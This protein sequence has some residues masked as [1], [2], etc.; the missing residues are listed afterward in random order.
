[1][2]G[3]PAEKAALQWVFLRPGSQLDGEG[4]ARPSLRFRLGDGPDHTFA[5]PASERRPCKR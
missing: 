3:L 2:G 5:W 4:C 1:M